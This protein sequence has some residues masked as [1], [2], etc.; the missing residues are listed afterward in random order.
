M[1]GITLLLLLILLP[2][3]FAASA[4]EVRI[5]IDNNPPLT[6][7]DETGQADG[8]FPEL[9]QQIAKKNNWTLETV[10]CN[11]QQCLEKLENGQIDILPAIAYTE[12]RAKKY[13][14]A[15][16]TVFTSWGQV[17]QPAGSTIESILQLDGKKLAVLVKDVYYVSDQGLLQIAEKFGVNIDYV[18]VASYAEAFEKLARGEVDA[19]MVGRIF[20]IK[21]RHQYKL[22]PAPIL[23]KPIQVR[24]AFSATAP[25]QLQQQF[26][27]T[28]AGWKSVNN[29]IYYQLLEKW[30]GEDLSPQLP[31]WLHGLMYTLATVLCLL[32][33]TTIWTRKQVKQKTL[34]LAEKNR[35]LEDELIERQTVEVELR[36]R[37]QQ[38]QVLFEKN[39]AIMLLIDPKSFT[40]VD[41]NPTACDFYQYPREDLQGM[42]I[43]ALNELC[44]DEIKLR[45]G[46]IEARE[47]KLFEMPH[48]LANGEIRPVEIM[49]SPIIV[50]GRSLICSIVRDI[51]K[52]KIAENELARRNY[53]LQSVI[54]G[55]SDPLMVIDFDYQVLQMNE[56]AKE[57]LPPEV[58][59]QETLSCHHVSHASVAPCDGVDHPCPIREV[60]ET[61]QPVTVVHNHMINKKLRIVELNASPLY[62]AEGELYAVIEVARDITERQ[63]VEELLSENEKRLHHL[64]HHDP[65]TD[66]PNRLLFEDRLQQA[67]SKARRSRKQ[68]ALFFLDLDH[69][70]E[71]NDNLG[72]AVGDLLLVD[73]AN[74]LRSCIRESDTVARLG[75]DE[76]LVLQEEVESIERV[77][78]M[79]E[80]I[81]QTLTHELSRDS[82]HQRVSASIGISIYPEDGNSGQELLTKADQ[83]MYQA[84]GKGKATYQFASTPQGFFDFEPK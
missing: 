39:Q 27:Q 64:A 80:R 29:S 26:D 71:I 25:E 59:E 84:K 28:L 19:A 36:E 46:Q 47:L 44:P 20:G 79:A 74:R 54:D 34:Q 1:R 63:Q 53:F 50:E 49:S 45:I 33:L 48:K 83:A 9:L 21:K 13:S 8:L 37:Q 57:Q 38:Y 3:P 22:R 78:Q 43:S 30:L 16:E 52:R 72:H 12:E 77:E 11:W 4:V 42:S 2:L 73:I 40:I 55:V 14:Y 5:G 23:I 56:A 7:V 68:V 60:Q 31:G 70:K 65:L 82:Y 61:G 6:F 24:P 18:E 35:L 69:F 32:L 51:S 15:D 66:L 58:A 41:A 67:L 75:G 10:P 62:N 17:Y 81:C 76:F